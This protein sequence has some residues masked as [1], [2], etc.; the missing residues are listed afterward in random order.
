[1]NIRTSYLNNPYRKTYE[2]FRNAR[3]RCNNPECPDFK[4]YGARGIKFLFTSFS[5][6]VE[7]MG[8]KPKGLTLERIDNDGH[9]A[10]GN[11]KWATM[12]EQNVNKRDS[13]YRYDWHR[14]V[15]EC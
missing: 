1:M 8:M 9:Y 2:S 12:R 4:Y 6:F 10:P 7:I 14:F 3:Y 15:G 11:V 13:P 5:Q